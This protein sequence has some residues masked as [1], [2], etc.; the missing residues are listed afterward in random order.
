MERLLLKESQLRPALLEHLEQAG[1]ESLFALVDGTANSGALYELFR[2]A[3]DAEYHPLFLG[4]EHEPCLPHSP[5]VVMIDSTHQDFMHRCSDTHLGIAWFTSPYSL[6]RQV[7]FWQ[8]RLYCRL[9][10][11]S[12]MLCRFWNGHILNRYLAA[13]S[14]EQHRAFLPLTNNVF[15][16][17]RSERLWHHHAQHDALSSP[18]V[19]SDSWT[20]DEAQLQP[21]VAEF[22][23]IQ[24]NDIEAALW[25]SIPNV[26]DRIH[27]NLRSHQ[28]SAGLV[29]G[30]QRGVSYHQALS[31]YVE[32]YLLWGEHFW[33]HRLFEGIWNKPDTDKAFFQC[34]LDNIE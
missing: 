12:T 6:N 2:Y 24:L 18:T 11:G 28:I 13:L 5:Y 3:P 34:L 19:A 32:C 10:E 25:E 4:T 14:A 23:R 31:R 22:K 8:N 16:P 17:V 1:G 27:P 15:T 20:I 33:R 29:S 7:D 9:P 26:L 21:F 30:Q